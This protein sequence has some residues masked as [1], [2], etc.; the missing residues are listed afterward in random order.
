MF[1]TPKI[2]AFAT[3]PA[4]NEDVNPVPGQ[5]LRRSSRVAQKRKLISAEHVI[6][7]DSDDSDDKIEP[8]ITRKFSPINGKDRSAIVNAVFE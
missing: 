2:G 6:L 4:Y 5:K 8:G 1:E 3:G 7:S